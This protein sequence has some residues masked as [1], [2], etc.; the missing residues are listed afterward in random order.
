MHHMARICPKIAVNVFL[1]NFP[2][3]RP[4]FL[5]L[6]VVPMQLNPVHTL[7]SYLLHY[8]P[9][10]QLIMFSFHSISLTTRIQSRQLSHFPFIQTQFSQLRPFNC[11]T[12][13][14][15][16][17]THLHQTHFTDTCVFTFFLWL[18]M[19]YIKSTVNYV[20]LN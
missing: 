9:F 10:P 4:C 19:R 6:D 12:A 13:A 11:A 1:T 7:T 8:N 14:K 2:W 16:L 18:D 17:K 20:S 3:L 5:K 15:I